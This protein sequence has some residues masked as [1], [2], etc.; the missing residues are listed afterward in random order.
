M[1]ESDNQP[2]K[3][4][5]SLSLKVLKPESNALEMN[6]FWASREKC[7]QTNDPERTYLCLFCKVVLCE[8][9]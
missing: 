5:H 4:K 6:K 3:R 2:R 7:C 8:A 9:C 1:E